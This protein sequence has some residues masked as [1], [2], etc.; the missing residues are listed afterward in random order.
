MVQ[1]SGNI[2]QIILDGQ[3][4]STTSCSGN[5]QYDQTSLYLGTSSIAPDTRNFKGS[6]D[7]V[8]I[9]NRALSLQ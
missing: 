5:I 8:A 9:W 3:V 7:D 4:V 2:I 1:S 6:L